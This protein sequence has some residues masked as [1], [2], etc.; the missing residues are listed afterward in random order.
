MNKVDIGN[1]PPQIDIERTEESISLDGVLDE[2]AWQRALVSKDFS[3]YFPFPSLIFYLISD[4]VAF[5]S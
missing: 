3:Q 4:I 2:P 5:K 1:E